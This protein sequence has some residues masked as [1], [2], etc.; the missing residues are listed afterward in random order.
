MYSG[1]YEHEIRSS[2]IDAEKLFEAMGYKVE[3][4][5]LVLEG[6]ICPDQVRNV[7]RDALIA[8]VE[9]QIMKQIYSGLLSIQLSCSWVDIYNFREM[10]IGGPSQ[11]IKAIA[12][13]IQEKHY[14]KE[15]NK[16]GNFFY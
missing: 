15:Q 1:F 4:D 7:S 12:F 3:N 6:A 14:H 5:T 8:Y 16:L 10:Y 9:C 2:L 11:A 13:N